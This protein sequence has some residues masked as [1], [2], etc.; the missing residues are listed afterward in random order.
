M[1]QSSQSYRLDTGFS[2]F[3][4]NAWSAG[5]ETEDDD[6]RC[7]LGREL[8]GN[9]SQQFVTYGHREKLCMRNSLSK[10][11][12]FEEAAIRNWYCGVVTGEDRIRFLH[13]QSTAD[14]QSEKEGQ[15]IKPMCCKILYLLCFAVLGILADCPPTLQSFPRLQFLTLG[16]WLHRI[17]L[18]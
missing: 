4:D 9:T 7:Y 11:K 3:N 2:F 12:K 1:S 8:S 13:N 18:V 5:A 15:V 16:F 10:S 6:D 17:Y 14:F